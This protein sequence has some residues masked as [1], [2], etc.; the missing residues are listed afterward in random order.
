MSRQSYLDG[1]MHRPAN[2]VRPKIWSG[3]GWAASLGC[4]AR[5]VIIYLFPFYPNSWLPHISL[6]LS[7]CMTS[8]PLF[9]WAAT[10]VYY[11]NNNLTCILAMSFLHYLC[12][13]QLIMGKAILQQL[14]RLHVY[15]WSI[16]MSNYWH[17]M[18]RL[19]TV[20]MSVYVNPFNHQWWAGYRQLLGNSDSTT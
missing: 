6:I 14:N 2:I 3:H 8:K 5:H 19:S 15:P 20:L 17:I 16:P 9:G 7:V 4:S 11:F 18:L 10:A 12:S 13:F 1:H